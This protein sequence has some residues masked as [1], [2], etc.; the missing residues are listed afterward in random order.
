MNDFIRRHSDVLSGL[1]ALA[2]IFLFFSKSILGGL[3]VSKLFL[4]ANRDLLF[5]QFREV[6]S[7]LRTDESLYLLAAPNFFT[8][9]QYWREGNI[10]L[11]N[12]YI[13]MGMP[14]IG[15]LQSC[16]FSPWRMLGALCPTVAYYNF[17][18]FLQIFFASVGCFLL[19]R[20]IG[21]GKFSSIFVSVVFP[22]SPY[23]LR[24]LELL[25][26]PIY[27]MYPWLILAFLMAAKNPTLPRMALAAASTALIV[28]TGHT[29][30]AV[31]GVFAAT[32]MFLIFSIWIYPRDA[33]RDNVALKALGR[34][35]II[36]VLS[37]L[38]ASP[39]IFPFLEFVQNTFCYKFNSQQNIAPW[40]TIFY[41]LMHPAVGDWSPSIGILALPL[42]VCGWFSQSEVRK[43]YLAVLAAS[44]FVYVVM[45][46]LGP[47][48]YL[49]SFTPLRFIPSTYYSY[50]LLLLLTIGAGFGIDTIRR[51]GF[52]SHR[53]MM[54]TIGT[55]AFALLIPMVI[56]L[57]KINM[58]GITFD[59]Q[60]PVP[61]LH[62]KFWITDLI[63][64]IIFTVGV[65]LVHAKKLSTA[66]FSV[67]VIALALV[68]E[69][70]VSRLALPVTPRFDFIKTPAHQFL[71]ECGERVSPQGFDLLAANSNSVYGIRSV[72]IH[73]PM[74]LKRYIGFVRAG[75]GHADDFNV[76][77]EFSPIS[78]L[79]DLAS[80]KYFLS[81]TAV[82][83]DEEEV[84]NGNTQQRSEKDEFGK[85]LFLV[86]SNLQFNANKKEIRGKLIWNSDAPD[87]ERYSYVVDVSNEKGEP[88][89]YGG[90]QPCFINNYKSKFMNVSAFLPSSVKEGEK[91][92]VGVRVFDTQKS[93]FVP[94]TIS[95][96]SKDSKPAQSSA[97]KPLVL[98]SWANTVVPG[99]ASHD[100]FKLV[101]ELSGPIARIYEN[102]EALP[103]A[104]LVTSLHAAD[105]AADALNVIAKSASPPRKE[106]IVEL[107]RDTAAPLSADDKQL[108]AKPLVP[109]NEQKAVLQQ[110]IS[111]SSDPKSVSQ[112]SAKKSLPV[113]KRPTP[114]RVIIECETEQPAFLVLTDTFY[115]GWAAT[116]DGVKTPVYCTNYAF[117][118]VPIPSGKHTVVFNFRPASFFV[119]V[120]MAI[121][122]VAVIFLMCLI[123]KRRVK[124]GGAPE[125]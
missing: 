115:P 102:T 48:A 62:M 26:G 50:V 123:Q 1:L 93:A 12:P 15:D 5:S 29:L 11:W 30:L 31:A 72:A 54:L 13:G 25:G 52:A 49:F 76:L 16:I 18:L 95:V 43:K 37:F 80:I 124:P 82:T 87:K 78:R 14:Q 59:E 53:K 69:L 20:F 75:H 111:N 125:Q 4:L 86:A 108:F 28:F 45:S 79:F 112:V 39:V 60:L 67:A 44:A 41:Y 122:A 77:I 61:V 96:Q 36:G 120:Y 118:G 91:F 90:A 65:F 8:V 110:L 66:K 109:T 33:E 23:V 116:V 117:R 6:H 42:L 114:N 94:R 99:T 103:Q 10:P 84:L 19:S 17:Q 56:H 119:G 73:N 98:A 35:T 97:D 92:T 27:T 88:F 104:Y 74:L 89:W 106:A 22:L 58:Q 101:K 55:L 57:A 9:A 51:E 100:R 21:L 81:F 107:N 7:Y 83:S 64:G 105:S 24:Y 85:G 32:L 68:S 70:M 2:I 121:G 113:V 34:I 3:P 47:L 40:Q 71:S 38:F 46:A 63:V